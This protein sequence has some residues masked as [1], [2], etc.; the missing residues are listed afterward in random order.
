MPKPFALL[1]LLLIHS[2]SWAAPKL[3]DGYD[4]YERGEVDTA[5]AIW[6]SLAE[7]GNAT[8]QLNLGQLYRLGKDVE[9]DDAK[10]V[11]WYIEA[12]NNG[13]DVAFYSL[14]LMYR[15]GRASTE[16]LSQ[17][18][19]NVNL[20]F[21][22]PEPESDPAPKSQPDRDWLQQAPKES[23]L[24]QVVASSNAVRLQ[25]Y[26]REN[27]AS[28][29]HQTHVVATM[30]E[31]KPWYLLLLGPFEGGTQASNALAEL[32]DEVKMNNP[33]LRTAHSVQRLE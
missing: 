26:A 32:P 7:Q 11:K 30:R 19:S 24:I 8:A 9:Q 18:I 12:A 17:V 29:G 15:E 27:L 6:T 21:P 23:Y 2:T 13:S 14:G 20:D 3:E 28:T 22:E 31:G 16:D 10:A 1:L 25:D 33:W 4:A 5:I